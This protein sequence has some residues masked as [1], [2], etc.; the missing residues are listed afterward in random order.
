MK[1]IID[2]K[3]PL[4][5]ELILILINILCCW[6]FTVKFGYDIMTMLLRQNLHHKIG[7]E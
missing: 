4:K 5:S 2:V 6:F 3:L 7:L 1:H